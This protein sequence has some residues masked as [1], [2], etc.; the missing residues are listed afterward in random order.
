MCLAVVDQAIAVRV[1]L[2]V[3]EKQRL[4]PVVGDRR[5]MV[6][7][8]CVI[9]IDWAVRGRYPGGEIVRWTGVLVVPK[10]VCFCRNIEGDGVHLVQDGTYTYCTSSRYTQQT[11]RTTSSRIQ[12]DR[13]R[14]PEIVSQEV[15]HWFSKINHIMARCWNKEGC[16]VSVWEDSDWWIRTRRTS[17]FH[18]WPEISPQ[19][20]FASFST[21][22][23]NIVLR[24]T[25]ACRRFYV[26]PQ[27][28]AFGFLRNVSDTSSSY[29]TVISDFLEVERLHR[30][31]RTKVTFR[32]PN[33]RLCHAMSRYFWRVSAWLTTSVLFTSRGSI[34][35]VGYL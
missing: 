15:K 19:P 2:S 31:G 33:L 30:K 20:A 10:R 3:P 14:W 1:I 32:P 16:I 6:R 24:V 18:S 17:I 4:L 8:T 27:A 22:W 35:H 11:K 28:S 26:R 9:Y 5:Q 12:M 25:T 7:R 13:Q 29:H 21:Q 23:A 34:V